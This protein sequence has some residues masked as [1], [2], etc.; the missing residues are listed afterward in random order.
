MVSFLATYPDL[1]FNLVYLILY[2]FFQK[3][4]IF[5]WLVRII[6]L[7]FYSTM[8]DKSKELLDSI[9]ESIDEGKEEK[10]NAERN[11]N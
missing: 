8:A 6:K 7:K 2:K 11:K 10:S 4:F 5:G 9:M 3:N 1:D